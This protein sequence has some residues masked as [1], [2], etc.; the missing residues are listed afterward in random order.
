MKNLKIALTFLMSF[1]ILSCSQDEQAIDEV[2]DN[3]TNGAVLR[4]Q[5]SPIQHR[6][7]C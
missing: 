2:F 1:A 3:V 6:L 5:S 7:T 4:T